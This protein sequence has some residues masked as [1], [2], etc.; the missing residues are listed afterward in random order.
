[1]RAQGR[2]CPNSLEKMC[3][4]PLW[5]H[6]PQ[7]PFFGGAP[8]QAFAPLRRKGAKACGLKGDFVPTLLRKR[9]PALRGLSPSGLFCPLA[10]CA[11]GQSMLWPRKDPSGAM[12]QFDK[13]HSP[14]EWARS[15]VVGARWFL[16]HCPPPGPGGGGTA[17]SLRHCPRVGG[18]KDFSKQCQ[19]CFG[20][21]W[22]MPPKT[23]SKMG[24]KHPFPRKAWA[25]K[26]KAPCAGAVRTGRPMGFGGRSARS[27]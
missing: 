7:E 8:K 16:G 25:S 22:H 2:L 12:V 13:N 23:K 3:Q 26:N 18:R 17:A 10:H 1:L 11:R 27:P 9:A 5:G 15:R 14:F 20:G 19:A 21:P 24:E 6:V 4:S